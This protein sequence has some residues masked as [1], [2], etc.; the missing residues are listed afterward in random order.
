MPRIDLAFLLLATLC[1]IVGVMLGIGMGVAHDF[2]FA[3][4][5]AH[6]NL[7]GW[8]SLALFG[9][10]Y[11]VYP[12][13]AAS[14]LAYSHLVTASVAAI[15]F[16]AGIYLS[17]AHQMPSVAIMAALLWLAGTLMFLANLSRLAFVRPP[18]PASAH[19]EVLA[20]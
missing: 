20:G 18:R 17:I 8:T 4:I 14:W 7:V 5:H 16:P 2:Q 1:L 10:A 9:L 11:R 6:L 12:Q 3:P 19:R 13:L 15:L